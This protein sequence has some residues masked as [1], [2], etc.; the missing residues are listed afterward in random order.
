[1]LSRITSMNAY[2][3]SNV[4]NNGIPGGKLVVPVNPSMVIYTQFEH[5]AGVAAAKGQSGVAVDKVVILNRLIEQL[6][7]MKKKPPVSDAEKIIS[8]SDKQVDAL[9]KDYQQQLQNTLSAAKMNPYVTAGA[10]APQTGA[11]FNIAV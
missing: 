4:L 7:S 11:I 3:Y 5:V 8:L 2:S 10:A 1:M 6:S 9:I